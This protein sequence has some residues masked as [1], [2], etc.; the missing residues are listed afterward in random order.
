VDCQQ[1]QYFYLVTSGSV[2]IELHSL[3]FTVSVG[4]G[5][6]F[7]WAA[8]LEH[9]DTV[10]QVRARE[11]T[12]PLRIA[13]P[14]LTQAWRGDGELS[15]EI[16]LCTLQ[17]AAGPIVATE[18]RFAEICGV[19]IK[20]SVTKEHSRSRTSNARLLFWARV[21]NM[22]GTILAFKGATVVIIDAG[23]HPRF[24]LIRN[25]NFAPPANRL[26]DPERHFVNMGTPWETI[27]TLAWLATSAPPEIKGMPAGLLGD[28]GR[29]PHPVHG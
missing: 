5:Q 15:V 19:R 4:P 16:L 17:V 23:T 6:A 2:N 22:L 12:S 29:R 1:S 25:A 27:S 28:F 18:E 13:G 8:V 11:L 9:Q 26:G 24:D 20:S 10:S 21:S 14:D 3:T 7:G